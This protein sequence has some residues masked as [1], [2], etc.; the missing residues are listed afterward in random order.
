MR[1]Y[2][3]EESSKFIRLLNYL[4]RLLGKETLDSEKHT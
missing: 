4:F 1:E 2:V 3:I